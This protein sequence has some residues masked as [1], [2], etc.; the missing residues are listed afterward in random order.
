M[1]KLGVPLERCHRSKRL[2]AEL[3]V[4]LPQQVPAL[5]RTALVSSAV[6]LGFEHHHAVAHLVESSHF[7]AAGALVRPLLEAVVVA[8]WGLYV[9]DH[10]LIEKLFLE[11]KTSA[12]ATSDVVGD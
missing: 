5:P 3:I 11:G 4:L 8:I 6:S 1:G 12:Q 9:A 2:T 7:G 10:M